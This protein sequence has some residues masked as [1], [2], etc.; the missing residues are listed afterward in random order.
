MSSTIN[1]SRWSVTLRDAKLLLECEGMR[2]EV[3]GAIP[4]A[5]QVDFTRTANTSVWHFQVADN[6]ILKWTGD[7]VTL[8]DRSWPGATAELRRIE[9]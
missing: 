1:D 4:A 3:L 7:E 6:R 8:D 2:F 5:G 9:I